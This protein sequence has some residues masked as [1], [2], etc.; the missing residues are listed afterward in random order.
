M[1]TFSRRKVW[2]GRS[3]LEELAEVFA[4]VRAYNP[5]VHA[6]QGLVISRVRALPERAVREAIVNG[7]AHREWI[8][9]RPTTAEHIGRTLR[10][11]SPGGFYGG[12]RSD[13]IINHPPVSRNKDLSQLLATLRIAERQGA[14]VDRMFADMIRHGHPLPAQPRNR[15]R[16]ALSPGAIYRVGHRVLRR[17][18]RAAERSRGGSTDSLPGTGGMDIRPFS[19]QDQH[20]RVR[21]HPRSASHE[22]RER[23]AGARAAGRAEAIAAEPS[24]RRVLL[25][26][27]RGR[28]VKRSRARRPAT[29]PVWIRR[30][31]VLLGDRGLGDPELGKSRRPELGGDTPR[32]EGRVA[33]RDRAARL[34][35]EVG[36]DLPGEKG[37]LRPVRLRAPG[38]DRC[39]RWRRRRAAR[40]PLRRSGVAE[41]CRPHPPGRST[42][43]PRR[44]ALSAFRES[45]TPTLRETATPTYGPG[46]SRRTVTLRVLPRPGISEQSTA[47][48]KK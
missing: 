26:A 9:G 25:P 8:D 10:V 32:N 41:D 47:L 42:A 23:P 4:L 30:S 45:G 11:T 27:H 5:E 6:E 18:H 14:G 12:V 31:F 16:P 35:G 2:S 36:N 40:R 34:T 33:V 24:R 46:G 39:A 28:G 13:N 3:V 22:H 7:I 44:R 1:H 17:S 21:Q 48:R 43:S 15:R 20:H 38:G 19:R 37:R 29:S